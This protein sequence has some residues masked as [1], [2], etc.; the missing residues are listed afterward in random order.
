ML[1]TLARAACLSDIRSVPEYG[2]F[3]NSQVLLSDYLTDRSYNGMIIGVYHNIV[4]W[5]HES[6]E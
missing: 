4:Q 6:S 5:R 1:E 2:T 3:V